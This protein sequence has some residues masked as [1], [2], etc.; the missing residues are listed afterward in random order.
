MDPPTSSES[1]LPFA[2]LS[3]TEPPLGVHMQEQLDAAFQRRQGNRAVSKYIN[4]DVLLLN[5][6]ADDLGVSEEIKKLE[7]VFS[8]EYNFSTNMWRIPSQDSEDELVKEILRFRKGKGSCDLL[9]LFYAGHAGGSA[10]ECVWAATEGRDSPR[11]NWHNVQTLLLGSNADVLVILDCCFAAL[12]AT[13]YGIG[14]NWLLCASA[15]ESPTVGVCRDSFTSALIRQL[16][17]FADQY[18]ENGQQFTVQSVHHALIFWEQHLRFTPSILRLA[19]YECGPTELTPLLHR[20]E[21]PRLQASSTYP[22]HQTLPPPT[23]PFYLDRSHSTHA[24]L[25]SR[26]PEGT[27]SS[28]GLQTSSA[29]TAVPVDLL[30]GESHTVRLVGLPS[31]TDIFDIQRWFSDRLGQN[32]CIPKIGPLA[33]TPFKSVTL[34]FSSPAEATHAMAIQNRNF[35]AGAGGHRPINLSRTGASTIQLDSLPPLTEIADIFLWLSDRLGQRAITF[36]V[37]QLT[38]TQFNTTTATFSSAARAR[39]V[40][41][42]QNR[43][44]QAGTGDKSYITIENEFTGLTCL[45]TSPN[46]SQQ[47]PGIDIILVHGIDGHAINSFACHY[48]KPSKEVLWPS[49][50]LPQMLEKAGICP[51]VMTFGW[52]ANVWLDPHRSLDQECDVFVKALKAERCG[53]TDRPMVFIGHGVG[54]LLVKQAIVQMINSGF[55]ER[56]FANPIKSCFFFAVPHHAADETNGFASILAKM[57]SN[58]HETSQPVASLLESSTS[59]SRALPN[60][61][62]EFAAICPEYG[63]DTVSFYEMNVAGS[64]CVVPIASAVLDQRPGKSH[65]VD[66]SFRNIVRLPKEEGSLTPVLGMM[67][68]TIITKLGLKHHL[69]QEGKQPSNPNVEKVYLRLKRYDTVIVV[70]D[71]DSMYGHRWSTAARVLAN[72]AHIAVNY[73]KDGIDIRFFNDQ[74]KGTNLITA[75][76]V[77]ELFEKVKPEGRTPTAEVLEA[78]L[79]SYMWGYK[80]NRPRKGLNL[81]VL[82]DGEP[83]PGQ[84]VEDVIVT[85]ARELQ[86]MRVPRFHVG[87]QFV[88]IGG[89]EAAS[90]FL[91]SL[92]D[93]LARKHQLDRDVSL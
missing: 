74:E 71:S 41:G 33:V 38:T 91:Q 84:K 61:S 16:E 35:P 60:L 89:D 13:N 26:I 52:H 34:T 57:R 68:D 82:T 3:M 49:V 87:I 86:A 66:A 28:N 53:I 73:D 42:I 51:R 11:L 77:M 65:A 72:I 75:Q 9:I 20:S 19:G 54:G 29:S 5:W 62:S 7:R 32:S 56:N 6:A 67:R 2:S 24:T 92:D 90:I 37:G 55:T 21:K 1:E 39:Q 76:K 44:F 64:R 63:I 48:T 81:I 22:V 4:V 45:Y 27:F 50:D 93:D 78:E 12:A 88:Q 69:S 83:D 14:D 70:D 36:E 25:P 85:F 31:S 23:T 46:W 47:S 17:K 80:N 10:R 8:N 40:L 15:K 30:P 18:R 59:L 43:Y 79:N 58:L